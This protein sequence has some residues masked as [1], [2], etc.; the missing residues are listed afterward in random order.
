MF[1]AK[2]ANSSARVLVQSAECSG[3]SQVMEASGAN[4]QH[5]LAQGCDYVCGKRRVDAVPGLGWS[6]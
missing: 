6:E 1:V 2:D 4:G 3:G 5:G